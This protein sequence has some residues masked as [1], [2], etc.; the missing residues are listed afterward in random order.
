MKLQNDDRKK[1]G[2]SSEGKN[3][4]N[5]KAETLMEIKDLWVDM[6]GE[7][8]KGLDLDIKKEKFLV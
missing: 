6:P 3:I 8:L 1:V 7:M 4:D 5:S 2:S